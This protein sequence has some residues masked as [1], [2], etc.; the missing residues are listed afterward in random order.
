[1][2][3]TSLGEPYAR[4]AAVARLMMHTFFMNCLD[5]SFSTNL[6]DMTNTSWEGSAAGGGGCKNAPGSCIFAC[7]NMVVLVRSILTFHHNNSCIFGAHFVGW[8][9]NGVFLFLCQVLPGIDIVTS[10]WHFPL[11]FSDISSLRRP[12]YNAATWQ[13]CVECGMWSESSCCKPILGVVKELFFF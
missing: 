9:S 8:L 1:M 4:Y 5:A 3:D 6:R 12:E 2:G 10:R 7:V 13:L 11:S